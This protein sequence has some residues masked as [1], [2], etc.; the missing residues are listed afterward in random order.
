MHRMGTEVEI[1]RTNHVPDMSW[2]RSVDVSGRHPDPAR[3]DRRRLLWRAEGSCQDRAAAEQERADG[4]GRIQNVPELQVLALVEKNE[5]VDVVRD[6][7][8]SQQ[9]STKEKMS[10]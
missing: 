8:E 7:L 5:R 6:G 10:L 4:W 3:A 2:D 1:C 9:K